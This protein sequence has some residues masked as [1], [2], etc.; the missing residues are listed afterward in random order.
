VWVG[1]IEHLAI[2]TSDN[3]RHSFLNKAPVPF[4]GGVSEINLAYARRVWHDAWH[5]SLV[6]EACETDSSSDRRFMPSFATR[7][8]KRR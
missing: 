3:A 5:E 1:W 7:I 2:L 8:P 4:V 6:T